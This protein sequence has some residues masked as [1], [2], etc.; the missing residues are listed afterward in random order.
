MIGLWWANSC[1]LCIM[2]IC[3][4]NKLCNLA[5]EVWEIWADGA[6]DAGE[7]GTS[8][9]LDLVFLASGRLTV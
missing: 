7:K 9:A 6:V 5:S 4:S 8:S 3:P 1:K 2:K